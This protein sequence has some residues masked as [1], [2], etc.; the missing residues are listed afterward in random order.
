MGTQT[1][2]IDLN[3]VSKA[4]ETATETSQYF[5]FTS[6]G[7]DNGAHITEV[8]KTTFQNTPIGG[9]VLATSNGLAVRD[10][11]KEL[12]TM[13]QGGFEAKTY[14][15]NDNEVVIA[16][17][18]YGPG[19]DSGGGTSDAPYYTLGERL[20]NS[21]IGNFSVASGLDADANGYCSYVEGMHNAS[22][23]EVCHAEGWYNTANGFA[24]H[25]EGQENTA[26][27]GS[28]AE[29][30]HGS[31]TGVYSHTQNLRTT[32][33]YNYQ[34]AIGKYNDNQS[35][36]ALEIGNGTSDN[37]RSNALTVDWS[38]NVDA[39]G[40][41]TTGGDVAVTGDVTASGSFKDGTG[42]R[43]LNS[44]DIV[45]EEV[46]IKQGLSVNNGTQTSGTANVTKAGA[47][48]IGIVGHRCANGSGSGGSYALPHAL[49]ISSASVG[50]ATVSYGIRAVGGN[51]SNC[52]LYATILWKY[53]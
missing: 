42:K 24:S 32:A 8:D 53:Q 13:E 49:Y 36:N 44:G 19:T 16:H 1:G 25:V 35:T 37:A 21:T 52:D 27:N 7:S 5:W 46:R 39:S 9:N 26:D 30:Y 51:V 33:G 15:S 18:G 40:G 23:G 22:N 10:G 45:S 3:A 14:D 34:T 47:Y 2:S 4:G 17:L 31:A 43:L 6:G 50:S 38:G 20:A 29:G 48:P 11:L 12:A 28:H 41:I